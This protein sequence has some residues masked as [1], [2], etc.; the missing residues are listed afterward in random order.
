MTY[1]GSHEIFPLAL[2][3]N[4]FGWT[5]DEATSHA[6]LDAFLAGGGSA[7][8]T[9]DSYGAGASES[10]IGSWLAR[11]GR[12]DEVFLMSK[13][14]QHPDRRGLAPRTVRLAVEEQL[15]RLQTDHLDLLWAHF[16][17]PDTPLEETLSTFDEVVR[18]G[19]VRELGISNYEPERITQWFSIV[20]D[21][22]YRAPI[23]LQ[24]E[25][26]LL[27][28]HSYEDQRQALAAEHHLAVMPYWGL[29]G[30]LL[31]GKYLSAADTKGTAREGIVNRYADGAAFEVVAVLRDV[32]AAHDAE[33]ATVAL[34][35]LLG[36]PGVVAPIASVSRP[37]QLPA[38]LAAPELELSVSQSARL[39]AASDDVDQ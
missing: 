23:A 13:V 4:S 31:T 3:T 25:Y 11:T 36:R 37:E 18:A 32:A 38:L 22:G 20:T 12:R 30:G 26:S 8:D 21:N 5:S 19:K 35:W 6:V 29:A 24:P 39:T 14:S 1:I 27:R 2:G 10:I 28:R 15:R 9:A 34:A 16:D 7:I 17:D 33:P